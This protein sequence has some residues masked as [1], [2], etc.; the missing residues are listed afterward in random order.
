MA[1]ENILEGIEMKV[2]MGLPFRTPTESWGLIEQM[3]RKVESG[4]YSSFAVID[5]LAYDNYEPLI[6]LAALAPMTKRLRLMTA[7][8]VGPWR[9][10]GVLAKQAATV[11]A[12]SGGRLTLGMGVGSRPDDSFVAPAE[13]HDRGKRFSEQLR[14]MKAIWR[15]EQISGAQRPVG[16]LPVRAGGPEVLI[17]GTAARAVARVGQFADGYVMGGRALDRDWA[18][19]MVRQVRTAWKAHNR[20]G[21]PRI[22]ASVLMALG[23]GAEDAVAGAFADY[24]GNDPAR[25]LDRGKRANPTT[26]ATIREAIRL[27]EDLGTDELIFRPARLDQTQVDRLTDLVG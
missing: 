15:G 19:A 2:G 25:T 13:F 12:I 18:Q 7:V 22:V 24:Y 10:A 21:E 9:N 8:L 4:P 17:G 16:P 5:R 6:L 23:P 27:H 20:P 26:P 14:L 11:D 1:P 3:V